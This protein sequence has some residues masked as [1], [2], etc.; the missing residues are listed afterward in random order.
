MKLGNID[1]DGYSNL[2]KVGDKYVTKVYL[3]DKAVYNRL[4]PVTI[5]ATIN[6][7]YNSYIPTVIDIRDSSSQLIDSYTLTTGSNS[8]QKSAFLPS[9]TYTAECHQLYGY[10]NTGSTSFKIDDSNSS[11]TVKTVNISN[12]ANGIPFYTVNISI[13]PEEYPFGSGN[14]VYPNGTLSINP[15]AGYGDQKEISVSNGRVVG[16]IA[17]GSNLALTVYYPSGIRRGHA[18]ASGS[19]S[20]I[21]FGM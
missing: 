11:S 12:Y 2:L 3:N 10:T 1:L 20:T 8:V 7:Q 17:F 18:T 19:N 13:S 4:Y 15:G 9:G 21:Y 14:Y 6:T 16:G 5:L